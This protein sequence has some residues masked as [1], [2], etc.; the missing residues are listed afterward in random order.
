MNPTRLIWRVVVGLAAVGL[1]VSLWP[2]ATSLYDLTGEDALP[3]QLAGMVH[4]LNTAVRPQPQLAPDQIPAHTDVPALG[5]NTFLQQEVEPEKRDRSLALS[6]A[7]GMAFIRQ[8]FTWEDIEIHAKGDFVDR[9]NDPEGVDAW[10]KYD[11]IVDLAQQNGIDVIARLSNPPGWSRAL[12]DEEV[13]SLAPPDDF[14][15]FGDFATAVAERYDGRVR[16]FQI[17]NEPNG[18]DEWGLRD[19]DPEAYTELLCLAYARIKAVNP[20]NI[21]LA[22]ALTPTVALNGRNM[23]DLIYLQRM[24]NAG[25]GD[26]FDIFSAQGYGLWSGATDQRLRPSVINFPHHLFLRDMLVRNGLADKAIW[27]SE[28]GWNVAP[29]GIAPNFGRVTEAQQA[30]YTVEAYE[31]AQSEWPWVGVMAYWFLKRPAD[32]EKDQAWYYFRLLEPDFTPLPVYDALVDYA[33]D[34]PPPA[35]RPDWISTWDSLR[36]GL[37]AVSAAILFFAL[38]RWLAADATG[39]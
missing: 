33:A 27:I 17:W 37:F 4:W 30:R 26:C 6:A 8:E 9:R 14:D 13:G 2:A 15:D 31:R 28:V 25:A 34:P 3:G 5:V 10:L 11:N 22:G 36:P 32:W 12:P 1:L 21:V 29:E 24:L 23:N 20:A 35:P 39:E 19:A 38:L 7:A 18:N 16:Y